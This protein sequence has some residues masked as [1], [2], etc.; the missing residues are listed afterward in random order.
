MR[1]FA[2]PDA[3]IYSAGI[4]PHGLNPRAVKTMQEAGIDISQHTSDRVDKFARE[5]F[6]Y[7][8]TVC[9]NANKNCPFFPGKV[10]RIHRSF[11]DPAKFVGSEEQIVY[12]FAEIRDQ[13]RDFCVDFVYH[14]I[15]C[16]NN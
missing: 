12:K 4:E 3:E 9:D 7:V 5:H 14:N 15:S 11:Y 8:I 10:V 16:V 2:G 6:D 13:I 1:T